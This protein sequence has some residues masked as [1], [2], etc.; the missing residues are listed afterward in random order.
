MHS[1]ILKRLS[2]SF[3]HTF[4]ASYIC[5]QHSDW[6]KDHLQAVPENQCGAWW[7]SIACRAALSLDYV[8]FGAGLWS[9]FV[10]RWASVPSRAAMDGISCCAGLRLHFIAYCYLERLSDFFLA[11]ECPRASL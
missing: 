5:Q 3:Y 1:V 8:S 9:H 4:P 11:P 2:S 10:R 6:S 7:L